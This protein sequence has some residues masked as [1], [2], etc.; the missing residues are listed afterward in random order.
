MKTIVCYGD[1]NTWGELPGCVGRYSW[2]ER[3]PG[4]LAAELGDKYRVIDEGLGGRTT[5][6]DDPSCP[7]RN[8]ARY[9]PV[10]LETHCPI[11]LLIIMLGTN[12]LKR[13]FNQTPAQIADG[14]SKLIE[15]AQSFEL[16]CEQ[17]L[18][19]AP[20]RIVP[21]E[22]CEV[23]ENFI[24]GPTRSNELAECLKI[25]TSKMGCRFFDAGQVAISSPIDGVHLSIENHHRLAEALASLI[26]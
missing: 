10:V 26:R 11:D 3:W 21:K 13:C 23:A 2:Q 18:I 17:I 22:Y 6:L 24:D 9:L 8:G 19:V 7:D 16:A 20:A 15:I 14:I 25:T 4:V 12:D 5:C 1:S